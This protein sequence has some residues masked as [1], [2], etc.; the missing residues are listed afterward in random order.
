MSIRRMQGWALILSALLSL[1]A[2]LRADSPVIKALL[3]AGAVL[4]ILGVPAVGTMQRFGTLG[5]AA[6]VLV[7]LGAIA[8]LALNLVASA[9]GTGLSDAFPFGAAL[10]G[11]LGRVIVGWL[12]TR[13]TILPAWAGWAFIAEGVINFLGGLVSIPALSTALG[14]IVVLLGAAALIGFGLGIIRHEAA[15]MPFAEA[16]PATGKK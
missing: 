16:I 5:W 7:E 1:L 12:T 9:G 15:G 4:L 3:L 14:F 2:I 6:I 10:A 13:E 8:A 11:A